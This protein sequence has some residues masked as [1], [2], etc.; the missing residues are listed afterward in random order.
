G[1]ARPFRIHRNSRACQPVLTGFGMMFSRGSKD[2]EALA[3][4]APSGAPADRGVPAEVSHNRSGGLETRTLGR[5]YVRYEARVSADVRDRRR[6]LFAPRRT[7]E[8]FGIKGS[9]EV[10][11]AACAGFSDEQYRPE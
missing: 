10:A 4:S 3:R 5:D 8:V 2:P 7:P 1:G 9:L 11:I 6:D